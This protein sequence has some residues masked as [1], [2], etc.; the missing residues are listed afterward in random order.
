MKS[1]DI[2][3][4]LKEIFRLILKI[5]PFPLNGIETLTNTGNWAESNKKTI[6]NAMNCRHLIETKEQSVQNENQNKLRNTRQHVL[7]RVSKHNSISP[8]I[9]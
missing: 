7:K 9:K 1:Q 8:F 3:F 4:H 5:L 2:N 6:T